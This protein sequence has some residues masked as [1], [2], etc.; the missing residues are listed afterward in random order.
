MPAPPARY[1]AIGHAC[2][3]FGKERQLLPAEWQRLLLPLTLAGHEFVFLGGKADA[4]FADLIIQALGRGRNLCG[5]LTLPQ[6]ARIL[7]H[8]ERFYGIDSLLLHLARALDVETISLWGP[9][10]PATRLRPM[11]IRE[12]VA[13]A[14]LPCSPCIHVN[15]APPCQGRRSCM[16]ASVRTMT[17]APAERIA[18]GWDIDPVR[19]RVRAVSIAYT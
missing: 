13:Y 10:D 18:V 4:P 2:S 8:A 17:A 19:P 16:E 5:Q 9:T 6:S 11:A 3:D 12:R 14:N 15:E 7:A 1:I